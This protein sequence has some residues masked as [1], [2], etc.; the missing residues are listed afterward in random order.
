MCSPL[1]V[2]LKRKIKA[3]PNKLTD[4]EN[5]LVVA[6]GGVQGVEEWGQKVNQNTVT[7]QNKSQ[8]AGLSK[9]VLPN[10][11]I[12]QGTYI[13]NFLVATFKYVK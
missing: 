7:F 13:I 10:R 3:K 1:Y 6:R 12:I 11:S 8:L 4:K 5:R 9:I 2:N